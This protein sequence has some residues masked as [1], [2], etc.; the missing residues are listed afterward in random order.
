MK[1]TVKEVDFT[2]HV[3]YHPENSVPEIVLTCDNDRA[4]DA[5]VVFAFE[6]GGLTLS[7]DI[8]HLALDGDE[9]YCD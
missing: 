3:N 4:R 5:I 9:A 2:I 8:V 1:F 7:G 6:R